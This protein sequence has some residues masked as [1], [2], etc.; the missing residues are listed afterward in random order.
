MA[1][2]YVGVITA[3]PGGMLLGATRRHSSSRFTTRAD[4]EGWIESAIKIN[5]EANRAV[6]ERGIVE[7]SEKEPEIA[8]VNE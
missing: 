2:S 7:T 8:Q 1:R 5:R 3:E 4:A 6:S